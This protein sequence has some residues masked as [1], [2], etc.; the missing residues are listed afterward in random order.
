MNIELDPGSSFELK[1]RAFEG[2]GVYIKI[3]PK[4]ENW[5]KNKPLVKI[6]VADLVFNGAD[7]SYESHFIQIN[8]LVGP[9]GDQVG[10]CPIE[11]LIEGCTT[12]SSQKNPVE[13]AVSLIGVQ[14][15]RRGGIL[16]RKVYCGGATTKTGS[17]IM[18]DRGTCGARVEACT[19]FGSSNVGIGIAGGCDNDIL[20]SV[21]KQC[22]NAGFAIHNY[23]PG[24]AFKNNYPQPLNLRG[25]RAI[26]C[27]VPFWW[28]DSK[29][30]K[31][32]AKR[33]IA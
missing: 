27:G 1:D 15:R 10:D 31:K 25:N 8:G 11:L 12:A 5:P 18:I 32:R 19:V 28:E 9:A 6:L 20:R 17:G 29:T 14:S 24:D 13:D 26:G 2:E 23:Y 16:I 3:P 33:R 21:A 7:G 30:A 22:V 4:P